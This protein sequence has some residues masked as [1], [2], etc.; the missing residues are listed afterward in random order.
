MLKSLTIEGL[1]GIGAWSMGGF[2]RYNALVG[3][4]G[5]GKTTVLE[6]IAIGASNGDPTT[7]FGSGPAERAVLGTRHDIQASWQALLHQGRRDATATITART[8]THE[9]RVVLSLPYRTE[10]E[11]PAIIRSEHST[12]TDPPRQLRLIAYRDETRVQAV[13]MWADHAGKL[14]QG[15]TDVLPVAEVVRVNSYTDDE[16]T[17]RRLAALA[18]RRETGGIAGAL[19]EVEAQVR[20]V[21]TIVEPVGSMRAY[22][23]IGLDELL[24][25]GALSSTGRRALELIVAARYA[26]GR[27]LLIDDVGGADGTP[28]LT[29]LVMTFATKVTQMFLTTSAPLEQ[30][31]MKTH[32]ELR[33]LQLA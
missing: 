8:G 20:D 29:H 26:K 10:E 1:R 30:L 11:L 21:T 15:R 23:D 5:T 9:H 3:A 2:G 27:V 17:A 25:V 13:D 28:L 31:R 22:A 4:P 32:A 14:M 24:P 18:V 19:A 7:A 16:A 33:C 6:A 12:H